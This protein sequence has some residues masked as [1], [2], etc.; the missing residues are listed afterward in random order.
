MRIGR[1]KLGKVDDNE[2]ILDMPVF[3]LT[4]M[5]F[6]AIWIV[7]FIFNDIPI[8]A[9]VNVGSVIIYIVAYLLLRRGAIDAWGCP[10]NE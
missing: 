1:C 6:H 5:I 4:S 3:K 8:M 10:R 7:M 2:E 9:V